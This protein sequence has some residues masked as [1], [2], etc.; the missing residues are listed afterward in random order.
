MKILTELHLLME[1]ADF[2]YIA[3]ELV[4]YYNL[5]SKVKMGSRNQGDYDFDRDIILLRRNYPSVKEFIVS[6]LHE[7]DHARDLKKMGRK[8]IRDYEK[9]QNMIAQ[10]FVKGKS[11]P[12]WD[13][14]YEIKAEKFGR[15]EEVYYSKLL[16]IASGFN[17]KFAKSLGFNLSKNY[18]YGYQTKISNLNLDEVNV[19]TGSTLPK[20]HFGWLVPTTKNEGLC[21]ILGKAKL[22]N[23]G[24]A[25]LL[26]MQKKYNFEI[27]EKTKVWGIPV[28]P[29]N[30]NY[31]RRCLLIGD[32]AGQVKPTTGGGIYYAMRSSDIASEIVINSLENERFSSKD[33]SL[34]SKKWEQLFKNELRIGLFARQFYESL[35]DKD[36]VKILEHIKDSEMIASDINFDWHSKIIMMAFK[37][38]IKSFL[39]GS[40]ISKFKKLGFN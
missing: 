17:S 32:V 9:Q 35:D 15:K 4:K 20:G 36:I 34:Y 16:I 22:K 33:L 23:N 38:K 12:Y 29:V 21:G 31:S 5:K 18:I 1:R 6:V 7:I 28:K 13:N 10:G 25:F 39:K 3:S 40:L 26:E 14:P 2:Q 24:K 27:K 19:F 37:T 8:F 30:K 11:D